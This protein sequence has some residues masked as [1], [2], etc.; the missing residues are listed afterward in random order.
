MSR[1]WFATIVSTCTVS[2]IGLPAMATAQD[3]PSSP[4]ISITIPAG[5]EHQFRTDIDNGGSFDVTRAAIGVGLRTELARDLDLTFS[6]NYSFAEYDFSGTGNFG[7]GWDDTHT[8]SFGASLSA[9]LTS[10]WTVFGGP[11]LQLSRESGGD[12]EDS[13]I[14]G[15]FFGATYRYSDDLTI[16]GGLGVM[17]Q[18][19][20]GTRLYP[21]LIVDWRIADGVKLTSRTAASATGDTGL[22]LAYEIGGGWEVGLGA[23]YRFRRFRLDDN[24]PVPS[25][26][27]EDTNIPVW[28]RVSY[29]INEHFRLNAFVGVATGGR[30]R[31]E[32]R[33][34]D[35]IA[36]EEYDTA[37]VLGLAGVLRF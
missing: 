21:I 4:S 28:A 8:L 16:G 17:S 36:R 22:E 25:G 6:F 5:V 14:A 31:L 18:I 7:D 13:L 12:W 26:V 3:A 10:D 2:L 23:A 1:P 34:G 30:L 9:N 29:D 20:D 32:D 27:G 37:P 15:G 11:A 24:G 19:E 35:R 33:S